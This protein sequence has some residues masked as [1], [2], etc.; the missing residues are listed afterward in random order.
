MPRRTRPPILTSFVAFRLMVAIGFLLVLLALIGVFLSWREKLATNRWFLW[1]MAIA[2]IL[3]YMASEL[4]WVL[5]EIGRQPWIVY[6]L[7]R[8]VDAASRNLSP[9]DVLGS[10]IGF[11]VIYSTLAVID[12]FLLVKYGRKVED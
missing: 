8:T 7:L 1:I 3:P 2:I 5:A 9:G 10:L 12:V 11:I 6:G 4:G